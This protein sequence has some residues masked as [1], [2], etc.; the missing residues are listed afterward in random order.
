M[1]VRGKKEKV[2]GEVKEKKVRAKK[3]K[4]EGSEN[5]EV[6]R[7]R[8]KV[9][10]EKV[11]KKDVKKGRPKKETKDVCVEGELDDLFTNLINKCEK[12]SEM[13]DLSESD[14]VKTKVLE[15]K[16]VDKVVE[17]ESKGVDVVKKIDFQGKKFLKSKNT[18]IV[19]NMDQEV[20]GKWNENTNTIDFEDVEEEE[21]EEY[22]E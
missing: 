8:P 19:Y 3:E 2:E 12:E 13:S 4:V 9:E 5:S 14:S 15:E 20:V 21:E 17:E 11:E 22:D 16:V 10:K 1:K 6:K 18:G 7:G